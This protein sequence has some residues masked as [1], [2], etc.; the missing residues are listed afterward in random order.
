MMIVCMCICMGMEGKGKDYVLLDHTSTGLVFIDMHC[1]GMEGKG[2]DYVLLDHTST[3]LVF[4]DMQWTL[5]PIAL[6]CLH[7]HLAWA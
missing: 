4:I 5:Y 6:S 3:G 7:W 1:M 2:K